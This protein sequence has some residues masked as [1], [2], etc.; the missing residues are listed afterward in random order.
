[1]PL[2]CFQGPGAAPGVMA[3]N[4]RRGSG[5]SVVVMTV[6]VEHAPAGE[7]TGVRFRLTWTAATHTLARP[8]PV[9]TVH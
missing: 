8:S 7:F 6:T 1:M 5:L 3:E 2:V 4:A 9:C